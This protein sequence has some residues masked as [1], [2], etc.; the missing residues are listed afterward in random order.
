MNTKKY[1]AGLA[2]LAMVANVA[3]AGIA[4]ADGS[5]SGEA[6]IDTGAD[7]LSLADGDNLSGG[8]LSFYSGGMCNGGNASFNTSEQEVCAG[9]DWQITGYDTD[10]DETQTVTVKLAGTTAGN[11]DAQNTSAD[12]IPFTGGALDSSMMGTA[13][14]IGSWT[15]YNSQTS[16]AFGTYS[17]TNIATFT[18]NS[19]A[20]VAEFVEDQTNYSWYTLSDRFKL[21]LTVPAAQPSGTYNQVTVTVAL[22]SS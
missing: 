15:A 1:L 5:A 12:D 20:T 11:F 10:S 18:D 3:V 22:T 8:T 21:T 19:A 14:S 2:T 16:G 17:E 13:A 7:A 6:T 4:M 9:I